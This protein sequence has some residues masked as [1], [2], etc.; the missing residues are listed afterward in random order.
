MIINKLLEGL[1]TP[2]SPSC[3]GSVTAHRNATSR[4][5]GHLMLDI[6]F[7]HKLSN[8]LPPVEATQP[9]TNEPAALPPPVPAT[10]KRTQLPY[11]TNRRG[12]GET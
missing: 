10:P 11:T 5:Y 8:H 2:N 6:P 9:E 1:Q 7:S 3:Y 4:P 12:N